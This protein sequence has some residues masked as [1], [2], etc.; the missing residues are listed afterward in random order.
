VIFLIAMVTDGGS[1]LEIA[2]A[3]VGLLIFYSPASLWTGGWVT[4][5]AILATGLGAA[6]LTHRY[7]LTEP[8]RCAAAHRLG[9]VRAAA[10]LQRLGARRRGDVPVLRRLRRAA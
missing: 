10:D 1:L 7:R 5:G 2:G 8:S 6:V 3:A 4:V 9:G